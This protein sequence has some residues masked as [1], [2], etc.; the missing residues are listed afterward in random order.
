[1]VERWESLS[2]SAILKKEGSEVVR[3]G[4]NVTGRR[5]SFRLEKKSTR[6]HEGRH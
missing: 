1:M 5:V 2:E 3:A 6:A 4:R